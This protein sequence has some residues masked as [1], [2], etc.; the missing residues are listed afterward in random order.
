MS[1][2]TARV[3]TILP[4]SQVEVARAFYA[5][6]QLGEDVAKVVC[7]RSWVDMTRRAATDGMGAADQGKRA[8]DLTLTSGE[9]GRM[10]V[11]T[12]GSGPRAD[13]TRRSSADRYSE[14]DKIEAGLEGADRWPVP[15]LCLDAPMV[16]FDGAAGSCRPRAR[17]LLHRSCWR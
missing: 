4:T 17:R 1:L 10:A 12:T 13:P 15:Y 2:A 5:D 16:A 9:L 6:V 14:P 7:G 3:T 8:Q 11:G